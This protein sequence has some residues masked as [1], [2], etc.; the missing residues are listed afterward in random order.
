MNSRRFS[1]NILNIFIAILGCICV[2]QFSESLESFSLVNKVLSFFG[3]YS[4][5]F[6]CIHGLEL[7]YKDQITYKLVNLVCKLINTDISQNSFIFI[8]ITVRLLL[9]TAV[10]LLVVSIKKMF[11][12]LTS[13]KEKGSV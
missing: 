6:M 2:I 3:R 5:Y 4:M 7:K 13:K 8:K 11:T 9:C 10:L 12:A 1:H